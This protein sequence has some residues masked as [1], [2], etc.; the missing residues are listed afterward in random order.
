M[1]ERISSIIDLF[2]KFE[3]E[4]DCVRYIY[5]LRTEDGW[6]CPKCGAHAP[7]LLLARRKVQCTRCPRQ[8]AVT[9]GAAMEGSRIKLRKWFVAIYLVANDKRVLL[10]ET[11]E[12]EPL[13]REC[14]QKALA[15]D[16][17]EQA[18]PPTP[19]T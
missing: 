16:K 7:S 5:E 14:Y 2:D 12:Y 10:G 13:C 11:A 18:A 19:N 15:N 17:R 6:A 3:T 8:E 4:E 1:A 9:K